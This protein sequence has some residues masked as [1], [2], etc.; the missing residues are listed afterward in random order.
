[1]V[2]LTPLLKWNIEELSAKYQWNYSLLT[3]Q[4]IADKYDESWIFVNDA[5]V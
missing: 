4:N 5:G 3:F 1:M 2:D